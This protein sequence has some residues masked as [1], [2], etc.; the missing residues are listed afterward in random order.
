MQISTC[1]R[2]PYFSRD[3]KQDL[4]FLLAFIQ[5]GIGIGAFGVAIANKL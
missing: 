4:T 1:M 5:L 3:V 2:N